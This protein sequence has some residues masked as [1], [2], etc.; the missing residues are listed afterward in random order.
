MASST[1]ST[2]SV[3]KLLK[4][5][6]DS[7]EFFSAIADAVEKK[8]DEILDRLKQHDDRFLQLESSVQKTDQKLCKLHTEMVEKHL[9]SSKACEKLE[10][11]VMDLAVD[12]NNKSCQI[13]SLESQLEV[14]SNMIAELQSNIRHLEQYSRRNSVRIFGVK[15]SANEDTDSIAMDVAKKVGVDLQLKDIDRSHRTGKQPADKTKSRGIIVKLCSYRTRQLLIS[16]RRKLKDSGI[17]IHEDLTASNFELL[18][19]TQTHKK[20]ITAW[21]SDGRV[22]A[23]LPTSG[24]PMKRLIKCKED[25]LKL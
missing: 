18:R 14:K 24:K 17:A 10:S 25:L 19:A 8:L 2:S 1:R 6:L 16:N 9:S 23:L 4:E 7:E 20:V 5:L 12:T 21:T 15:E 22:I 11:T 3:T 13:D